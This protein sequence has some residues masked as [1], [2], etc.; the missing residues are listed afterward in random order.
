LQDFVTQA[1]KT[2]TEVPESMKPVIQS[3]IDAGVLF[4]ENG[5][6]ITDMTGTGLTFGQTM[7]KNF[8]DVTG[9]IEHLAQVLEN[10]LVGGFQ[11]ATGAASRDR[12]RFPR[13][14]IFR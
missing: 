7:T 10:N 2:G 11:T 6:K 12:Q 3:A 8:Q 9:A 14:A 4:D 13:H 1:K 5:K